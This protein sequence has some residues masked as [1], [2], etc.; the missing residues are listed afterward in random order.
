MTGRAEFTTPQPGFTT[1][2]P[3]DEKGE[4]VTRWG[5]QERQEDEKEGLVIRRSAL[6]NPFEISTLSPVTP[7]AADRRA[8]TKIR[9]SQPEAG[10]TPVT[11]ND[12]RPSPL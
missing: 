8:V 11:P 5:G 9:F 10:D 7:G 3:A 1:R 6:E 4:I 12:Q 2:R